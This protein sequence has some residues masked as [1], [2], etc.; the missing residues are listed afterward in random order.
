MNFLRPVS[1]ISAVLILISSFL[2]WY[3]LAGA[4]ETPP[5]SYWS[6]IWLA[7]LFSLLAGFVGLSFLIVDSKL[8]ALIFSFLAILPFFIFFGFNLYYLGGLILFLA[9]LLAARQ[10]IQGEKQFYVKFKALKFVRN[11]LGVILFALFFMLSTASY[12][13][14]NVQQFATGGLKLPRYMFDMVLPFA[15]NLFLPAQAGQ[16]QLPSFSPEKTVDEILNG[17]LAE[18]L[19]ELPKDITPAMI[20]KE[21]Q[22]FLAEQKKALAE[23]FGME[24]KGEQKLG[25]LL[26]DLA[27]EKLS[28]Y[29]E[30]YKPFIPAFVTSALFLTL[31]TL[32]SP[33]KWLAGLFAFLLFKLLLASGLIV[34]S[35]VKTDKE[36]LSA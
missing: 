5:A 25:D 28:V 31:L 27:N 6:V 7:L 9:L 29:L 34:I 14:P 8:S 3:F 30:N 23:Q 18:Q 16:Q 10:K 26:Y 32:I 21:K 19:K 17:L 24:F 35:T 1:V 12:F 11:G 15:G 2:A 33:L 36:V 22:K 13:S 20:E 4:F